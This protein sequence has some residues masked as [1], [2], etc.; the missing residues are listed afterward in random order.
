MNRKEALKSLGLIAG[1]TMVGKSFLSGCTQRN[2]IEHYPVIES[3]IESDLYNVTVNNQKIW[4]EKYRTNMNLDEL[5]DWFT[6]RPYTRVQQEIHIAAFSGEDELEVSIEVPENIQRAF[7]R[8]LSRG[9]NTRINGNTISFKVSGPD[10]LY[11]EINDLPELCLFADPFE[12]DVPSSE[13][14]DVRYF[15]PGVH[16]PGFITLEENETLY[17]AAGAIVY[18]GIRADGVKNIRVM[19]RGILDGEYEYER[20]V[21][22]DNSSKIYF[23]GITIRNGKNW[24]NT[25]TNCQ[26]VTYRDIKVLSFGNSGDGINPLG[27][28]DFV[29]R[30]CFLRCTDD[31]IAVKTPRAY[32]NAENIQVYDNTMVGY[33]FSDGF[34]IGFETRGSYIKNI[35]V[36]NCD[37]LQSRGGSRVD[38]HSAFSIV[39]DGPAEISNIRFEDIRVERAEEKLFELI[40]TD[41]KKYGNDPPGHIRE[42]IVRNV[43]WHHKGEISLRG[44]NEDH[45]VQQLTFENCLVDDL[46]LHEISGQILNIGP[47]VEN[48]EFLT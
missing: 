39:C 6:S 11:I 44:F 1:G 33:A 18:G 34:T 27:C 38:G 9:I 29:I 20:M 19:G 17:I 45:K 31:C 5:P 8:P 12:S 40:I 14:T 42:I 2:R 28:R 21:R 3:L 22:I 16:R 23:E 43:I 48:I 26:E 13:D 7:I 37:I 36:K 10:R 41:G 30:N 15:G 25:L 46:P 47:F 35:T 32:L 4:I 24:I